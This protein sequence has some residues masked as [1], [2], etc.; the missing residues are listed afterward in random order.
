MRF[1]KNIIVVCI[2][3]FLLNILS[4]A[5]LSST[6]MT[7]RERIRE[8]IVTNDFTLYIDDDNNLWGHVSIY[9]ANKVNKILGR[10]VRA[11]RNPVLICNNVKK[12]GNHW[13]ITTDGKLFVDDKLKIIIGATVKKHGLWYVADHILNVACTD[14]SV[15]LLNDEN[16]LVELDS[17]NSIEAFNNVKMVVDNNNNAVFVLLDNGDCYAKGENKD[18]QIL[19]AVSSSIDHFIL[20]QQEV[21]ALSVT[22]DYTYYIKDEASIGTGY[23]LG[24]KNRV[25]I[26]DSF[27][28]GCSNR[29]FDIIGTKDSI[30]RCRM[31][32]SKQI[33]E[34]SS[35]GI[36]RLYVGRSGFY[37]LHDDGY[38]MVY[39]VTPGLEGVDSQTSKMPYGYFNSPPHIYPIW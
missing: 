7:G 31:P 4:K 35:M 9:S 11:N 14:E 19:P 1:C 24:I 25:D 13:I 38:V 8:I 21:I 6:T 34:F 26:V 36:K 33:K 27:V 37:M 32:Q 22:D 12:A 39:G 29:F 17:G 28:M 16:T 15:Y 20:V 10:R 2:I 23:K 18:G 30:I 3:V 5:V